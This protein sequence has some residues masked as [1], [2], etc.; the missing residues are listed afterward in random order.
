MTQEPT[1][2]E[3]DEQP[4]VA[5]RG[6]VAMDGIAQF[7][8]R[9][10][11]VIGWIAARNIEPVG[12]PFFK[13][14]LVD[15]D[16]GLV[17]EIGFPVEERHTG[18]EQIVGGVLPAGRYASVTHFGHPDGLR[19]ATG[20][21][22]AWAEKEGLEWD[23]DGNKWG[24]RLEVYKSDPREVPDMNDWETELLFRLRS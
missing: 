18:E 5:L 6:K 14:D 2:V 20:Q 3:R 8:D 11:E 10:H 4:Y 24:C 15:M 23:A 13:Y 9:L 17:M 12:A 7:A 22:L 19:E 21:L 1:I 16:E